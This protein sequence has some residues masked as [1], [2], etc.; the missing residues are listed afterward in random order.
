M[1]IEA[2]KLRPC[3]DARLRKLKLL[4]PFRA[5]SGKLLQLG[6]FRLLRGRDI[7]LELGEVAIERVKLLLHTVNFPS[8]L[9]DILLDR[10]DRSS[11][12]MGDGGIE[13]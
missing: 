7:F 2:Q 13:H 3:T 5:L 9:F 11:H 12:L 8:L 6:E 4:H 1:N 10:T